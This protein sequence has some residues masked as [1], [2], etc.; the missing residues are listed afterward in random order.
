MGETKKRRQRRVAKDDLRYKRV[1]QESNPQRLNLCMEKAH[2]LEGVW[3]KMRGKKNKLVL[4]S[5]QKGV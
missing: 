1:Q 2:L 3:W 4:P 5:V